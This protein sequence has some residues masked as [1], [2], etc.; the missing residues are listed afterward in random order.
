MVCRGTIQGRIGKPTPERDAEQNLKRVPNKASKERRTSPQTP[1]E[2]R[3]IEPGQTCSKI[4]HPPCMPELLRTDIRECR[5]IHRHGY[6]RLLNQ[7]GSFNVP[8][9]ADELPSDTTFGDETKTRQALSA[10]VGHRVSAIRYPC[11]PIP[12]HTSDDPFHPPCD[13]C[14]R[15]SPSLQSAEDT[16]NFRL[17][18][19]A[20]MYRKVQDG[21]RAKE[22]LPD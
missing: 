22:G 14:G 12:P 16:C 1:A 20:H 11:R 7:N 15:C 5:I 9:L 10:S 3:L 6:I 18:G 2:R 21:E 8:P 19:G 17:G 13:R 4:S